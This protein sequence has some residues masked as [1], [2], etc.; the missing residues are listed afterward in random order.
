MQ[1]HIDSLR[2]RI[3]D[4]ASYADDHAGICDEMREVRRMAVEAID[5][6]NSKGNLS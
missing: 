6:A 5:F 1:A 4:I 2:E 3:E